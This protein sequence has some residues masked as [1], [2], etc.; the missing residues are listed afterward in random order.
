MRR[1]RAQRAAPILAGVS[2]ALLMAVLHPTPA[3]SQAPDAP[4]ATLLLE[5]W[6]NGAPRDLVAAFRQQG[7]RLS[8]PADQF[9]GLGFELSSAVLH[10]TDDGPRIYL[11]ELQGFTWRLDMAAQ[12]IDIGAP[13]EA[14]IPADLSISPP[15][16]R[17][18][19]RADWS[20]FVSYDAFGE[21]S[22]KE[23]DESFTRAVSVDLEGRLIGPW[24]T[25]GSTG[26]VSPGEGGA[27]L[28]RLETAFTIDRPE[29][30]TSVLIGD[31]YTGALTWT[32]SVRFGGLQFRRDFG[33]RPDLV[34][35]PMPHFNT[36]V[37]AP[38]S[39][40]LFVNGVERFATDAKP[41][42]LRVR[43]MPVTTGAN[44]VRLVL[45]DPS[46]RRREFILPFYVSNELLSPGLT[47]F[48]AEVGAERRDY[49]VESAN[50]GD[51]FASGSLRRGLTDVLTGE[52]H[53][54]AS[55]RFAMVGAGAHVI[56]WDAVVLSGVAA[57]SRGPQ[58]SGAMWSVAAERSGPQVSAQVRYEQATS[59]FQDLP[60]LFGEPH[61]RRSL[62]ASASWQ[63]SD[64]LSV[65]GA[66]VMQDRGEFR[67]QVVSGGLS[68][69][70]YGNRLRADLT[71]YAD[72]SQTGEWGA[73]FMLS[74]PL[75][76]RAMATGSATST[77]EFTTYAVT[78]NGA[79]R[80]PRF[81]WSGRYARGPDTSANLDLTW[82]GA[83]LDAYA[84]FNTF[85]GSKSVQAQLGQSFVLIDKA[86]FVASRIDD[87]FTVVDLQGAS[88]VE[89]LLEN[90]TVGRTGRGGRLLI[91]RLQG[92]E[93]NTISIAPHDLPI[94]AQADTYRKVAAPRR[95]SGVV[96]R[97]LIDRQ[98]SAIVVLLDRNQTP[99]PVGREVRLAGQEEP[100]VLGY[101][102]EVYLRGLA[103]GENE[104]EVTWPNG[105]CRASFHIDDEAAA[106]IARVTASPCV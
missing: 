11:D 14:L 88:G 33:L 17:V 103:P 2:L 80:D 62:V 91:N 49:A 59:T 83:R 51:V 19:S 36:G 75:G 1:R 28:V 38:S 26:F 100:A 105:S 76:E 12:T 18:E 70:F 21:W 85:G 98:L 69:G 13:V 82:E 37:A 95:G 68:R 29:T 55:K 16:P 15:P 92:G 10:D 20:A 97:F 41:G 43:D 101:G 77:R 60:A 31:G 93:A 73:T 102:G 57:A 32:R 61:L 39:L 87:A 66:Y 54:E 52:L 71:G 106:N 6:V 24:F 46:G 96:T 79:G 5:V 45:T 53:G 9:R 4:P 34:T 50:Y 40:D 84:S 81:S 42:S 23:D 67:S 30:A 63:V 58:G 3:R 86:F 78:A 90:R 25:F 44:M 104:V 64:R 48:T 47:D 99:L 89:V 72:L 27:G 8:L 94:T 22:L 74:F 7:G 35:Q 56:L 65:N